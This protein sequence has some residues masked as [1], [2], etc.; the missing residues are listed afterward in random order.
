MSKTLGFGIL[1]AGLVSPFH[2]KSVNASTGGKLIGIAD[3][4]ATRLGKLTTEF[5]C[6]GYA[7]LDEMLK[8]PEIDAVCV[9]TPNHLHY[10]AVLKIAAAKK[11]CLT[12][13]PPAMSL[14]ET[15]EMIAACKKA[16]VKF[17]CTVQCRVRKAMQ[18][19]KKAINS[20]R[21]GTLLQADAYMKW[22]RAPEYYHMDAWRSSRQSGA[23]V[24]VQHAFHYIDVLQF[25]MGPAKQ[26]QARMNNLA[27]KD[28]KLEDTLLAFVDFQNGAQG[29]VQ[30]ST[31]FWPGTDVRIEVNGTLGTAIMTGE[32]MTTW[33]FK[34][35][36]PED[37][38][39][40]Q[41]GNASQ[42]TA[43]TGPAA[44]GF[45][46]HAVVIQ[47]LIDAVNQNREVVIPVSA[48]RPTLE[49]VLAMYHSAAKNAVVQLPV[50]DDPAIWKM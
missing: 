23:G 34:D 17:G 13:K 18:E 37:E 31:A 11:H 25:L 19:M 30:A 24:T 16:N 14:R 38:E 44:F 6:K 8:D 29:V 28:V 7:S 22:Y 12:E 36:R 50:Q 49:M 39:I 15:D 5:N 42:G 21:F 41:I 4:D 40:R 43:A 20:G 33:K 47:D 32:K 3:V 10:E 1:G 48:V 45:A 9:C 27:H 35:E 46:D 26:V 2:A